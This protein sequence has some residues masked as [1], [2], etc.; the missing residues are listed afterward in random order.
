MIIRTAILLLTL[1]YGN[2]A[3]TSLEIEQMNVY[4]TPPNEEVAIDPGEVKQDKK[5]DNAV[6]KMLRNIFR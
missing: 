1:L 5:E 3:C 4:I 2:I 6:T